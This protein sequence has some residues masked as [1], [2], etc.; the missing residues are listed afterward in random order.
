MIDIPNCFASSINGTLVYEIKSR[1]STPSVDF[2][3]NIQVLH[4]MDGVPG[5][6]KLIGVVTDNGGKHLKSYLIEFPKA[7]WNILQ[8]AQRPSILW[9]RRERW[10]IQIIHGI[11]QIHKREAL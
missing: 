11:S 8:L 3:Y 6:A 9:E 4:C 10:A 7:R 5:F 2:L 1:D